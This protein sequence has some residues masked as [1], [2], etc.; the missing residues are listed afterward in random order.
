MPKLGEAKGIDIQVRIAAKPEA[1]FQYLTDPRKYV[2]W[3]GKQ[4]TLEPRPGGVYRVVCNERDTASGKY[5]EVVPNKRVVFTWGW[6]APGNPVPPGSSTV[7]ITLAPDGKGTLLK[8]RHT[9]LPEPTVEPHRQG[10]EM[11]VARLSVAATG[12]DPGPDPN[13]KPREM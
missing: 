8:L 2:K 6:E 4:V 13:A 12:G 11:Y 1:V 3:M 10:W 5:V 9:G 7:E